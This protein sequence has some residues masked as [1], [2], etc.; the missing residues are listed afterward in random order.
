MRV[1]FVSMWPPQLRDTGGTRRMRRT[2]EL[3]AERGH[4]VTVLCTR[5]WEGDEPAFE[6]DGVVYRAVTEAPTSKSFASKLPFALRKVSPD[7]IQ[8][9]TPPRSHVTAV[10]AVARF[11]RTPTVVDWWPSPQTDGSKKAVR[12]PE[13]VLAP[14]RMVETQ[15]RQL[16]GSP[17]KIRV[18]P[19]PID[20]SL[21]RESRIDERADI[22]YARDLDEDANLGS[23]FLALA[24]LRD[25]DWRAAVIGDGP[26]RP[27][28]ERMAR[29]LRIDDCVEFLGE[30]RAEEGVP[31]MKGAK[32]FAQ[33]AT[34]EP[35]ATNL[36]WALACGCVGIVEYQAQSSAHELVEGRDRGVRVTSPQEL[37]DEIDAA[38]DR[39]QL[40]VNEAYAEFDYRPVLEQYLQCYR[41]VLDDTGFF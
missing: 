12:S 17:S 24:E 28:A 40:T 26:G 22:V 33:T 39:E 9:L 5:W 13:A 2:A 15:V 32:V 38:S 20:M 7:V 35:F 41:D 36:L 1:A 37:A 23:L 18:V 14:S 34:W 27:A 4:D 29:D 16:G 6:Q 31:I 19:E 30:L 11:T 21:V 25:R 10:R 3:L 8:L